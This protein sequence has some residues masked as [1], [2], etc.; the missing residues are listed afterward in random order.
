MMKYKAILFDLDDTLYNRDKAFE[1]FVERFLSRYASALKDEDPD[2]L[3]DALYQLDDHGYKSRREMFTEII[4]RFSWR[5]LPSVE[6]LVNYFILELP[7]C[8]ERSPEL[9]ETL[10]WC[11][12]KRIK[13]GIVTN[14]LAEMQKTKIDQLMIKKYMN[15]VIISEEVGLKKP[16]PQ[17]FHLALNRMGIESQSTLFVGD[18][19]LLDVKG[20]NDSGLISV[21]LSNGR[22]WNIDSYQPVMTIEKLSELTRIE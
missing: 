16:D 18:N 12:N 11:F 10:D 14:G 17:I 3:R 7:Q 15:T 6:E 9:L 13:M 19:P 4:D 1:R 20:A 21:W 2:S 22:I 8:V 5:H